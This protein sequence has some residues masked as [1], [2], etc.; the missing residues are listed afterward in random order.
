MYLQTFFARCEESNLPKSGLVY[1]HY[2]SGRGYL[3]QGCAPNPFNRF[4]FMAMVLSNPF[5][6]DMGII[7]NK[8]ITI[9]LAETALKEVCNLTFLSK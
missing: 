7:F 2:F 9:E 4:A 6:E 8:K 3:L 5:A 1:V